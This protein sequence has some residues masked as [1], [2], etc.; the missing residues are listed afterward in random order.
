MKVLVSGAAVLIL[1][2]LTPL[3]ALSGSEQE[4]KVMRKQ[5]HVAQ[6]E[7]GPK[8]SKS[9]HD[10]ARLSNDR[11]EQLAGKLSPEERRVLL[12]EGTERAF[13]GSLVK[14][15][16]KGVYTCRLCGLPLYD[17]DAKF[18]SGTGWPSFFR[19]L[20]PAHV[21][22]DS[23]MKFGMVRTEVECA[24]CQSHLGHVFPDGPDPTGVRYCMNSAALRFNAADAELP[25]ESRPT[26][27]ATAYFAGGCFWGIED[28]FQQ[29]PGVIDAVSGYQG[30][31][32]AQPDY[33]QVCQ[34]GTGHAETVRVVFNPGQVTYREL[35]ERFFTFHNPMQKNRQ[36]PDVGTQYRSAIFAANDMQLNEAQAFLAEQQAGERF[37]N[38]K[39]ATVVEKAGT[40]YEAEEYHQDYRAKHGGSCQLATE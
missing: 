31:H 37:R 17:S 29:V 35:L 23:D 36:G 25:P 33:K 14:N 22:E 10:I 13:T 7:D 30:G 15:K 27:P 39:I 20:D 18:E 5:D 2:A 3:G 4:K 38:G 1:S 32:V 16:R 8:Y 21:R 19:P 28:Q 6:S 34:G 24:R 12:Q 9:G 40:F 26:K 11:I